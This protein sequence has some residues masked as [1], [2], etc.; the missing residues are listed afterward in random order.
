VLCMGAENSAPD[1]GIGCLLPGARIA[2]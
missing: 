2:L 1:E